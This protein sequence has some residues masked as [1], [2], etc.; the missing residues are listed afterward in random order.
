MFD[1]RATLQLEPPLDLRLWVNAWYDQAVADGF[2]YPPF[3]LDE[4]IAKRLHGYF[5][6][7]LTPLEGVC[8][9]FGTVH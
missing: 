4:E 8:A 1:E 3:E 6:V 5:D 9:L 2:I 7:G